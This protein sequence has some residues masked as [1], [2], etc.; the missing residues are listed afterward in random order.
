MLQQT[1][2][3][4]VIPYYQRFLSSFPTLEI[5]AAAPE[6]SVLTL[7]AGLGYYSRAKNLHRGAKF[8]LETYRGNFPKNREEIL[9]VPGIGPY[10]AG[11]ILS[12]AFNLKVPLV[13]GNVERVF[14]RYFG[15]NKPSDSSE[16]KRFFWEKAEILVQNCS[17][18]RIFNQGL[19]ELGSL[20]CTKSAPKCQQCPLQKSCVAL[21]KDWVDKLP[22]K[23][24]KKSYQDLHLLKLLFEK[25]GK[26]WLRQNS[27]KEWWSGLWDFPTAP[28]KTPQKW[29]TEVEHWAKEF[30]ASSWRDLSRQKHTVT[31][32]RL[33]ILPVHL[34]VKR[35]PS[36][37][38]KWVPVKEIQ[39]LPVSALVKKIMLQDF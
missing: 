27:E 14:S 20:V 37:A 5:L 10:T 13:D 34:K 6:D 19:M 29:V 8:L 39:T 22:F 31:H 1:Q 21:K 2:V 26:L 3:S 12:I 35:A 17:S 4:T 18:P 25:D 9:K 11:A 23:K 36:K 28:L 32:H 7:W 33:D 15:F 24:T 38:G 16:A 30:R